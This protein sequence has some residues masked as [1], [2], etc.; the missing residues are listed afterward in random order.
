MA[1]YY[2]EIIEGEVYLRQPPGRRHEHILQRLFRTLADSLLN[3]PSAR[4]LDVRSVHQ[5]TVGSLL[6][7]D[8]TLV[9]AASGR[10]ILAV[11]VIDPADHRLDTVDK[12]ELY[13]T[14][15]VPRLWMVDPRYDNIEV[16]HGSPNGLRLNRI[17][18]GREILTESF[19]PGLAL[20]LHD[21]FAE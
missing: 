7:P 21:L 12:K 13:E 16:Y 15:N 17:L 14:R 11:E 1:G 2:E 5:L 3:I 8:L 19:L 20:A 10:L 18:A 6:R 9:T 4:M